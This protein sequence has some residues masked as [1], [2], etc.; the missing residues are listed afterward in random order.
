MAIYEVPLKPQPQEFDI[1]L[2]N[3]VR[4]RL[5][6]FYNDTPDGG[7]ALDI[8]DDLGNPL[9]CGIPLV[10][11]ANLLA[12]Y[13]YVGIGGVMWVNGDGDPAAVPLFTNL[14]VTSHLYYEV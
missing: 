9:I 10:T 13:D 11:G 7:W 6:T 14:G 5:R 4:Y 2:A 12:Q 1:F 8:S 3:G